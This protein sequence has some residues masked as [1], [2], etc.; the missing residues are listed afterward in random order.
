MR[1][2]ILLALQGGNGPSITFEVGMKRE[3]KYTPEGVRANGV[4]DAQKVWEPVDSVQGSALHSIKPVNSVNDSFAKE[5]GHV[6]P[7]MPKAAATSGKDRQHHASARGGSKSNEDR[8]VRLGKK[9]LAMVPITLEVVMLR[10]KDVN[11]RASPMGEA[12][13][14]SRLI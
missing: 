2:S 9:P 1:S 5:H 8:A 11:D 3:G 14:V 7:L 13:S 10:R 12:D 4:G 6:V